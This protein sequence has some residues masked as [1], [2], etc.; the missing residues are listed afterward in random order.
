VSYCETADGEVHQQEIQH[1]KDE[2]RALYQQFSG[3]AI[4]GLE[5]S[6]YWA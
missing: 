1:Q 4:V 5:A 2:V 3:G 6:G